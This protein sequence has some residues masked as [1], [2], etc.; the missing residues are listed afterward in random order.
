MPVNNSNFNIRQQQDFI[1][2]HAEWVN[3]S[4]GMKCTCT[5]SQPSYLPDANRA[6]PNCQACHGL[7]W[8]WIDK[9]RIQGLV[10]NITQQKELLQAG[11]AAPGDLLLSPELS[12]TLSD[13]D[14]I[15]LT[16]KEGIP[17]EG[18]LVTRSGTSDSDKVNYSILE[19]P[20]GG[21]ILV[22]ASTGEITQYTLNT[23]FTFSGKLIKWIGNSPPVGSVYSV[24]YAALV[25]WIVFAPPQPR[26]ERAT[27]LGQRV[28][29][30]K[31]HVVFNGQ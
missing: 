20:Q 15:Q 3:Y 30:R 14:K 1:R 27:N 6:N 5:L 28:I 18:Q 4:V 19:I 21:I 23:D 2:R 13:Y 16:W 22:N 7:G 10:E 25:D 31:K 29:L 24:K 17:Y 26:R 9:G 12:V 11:I 8:V